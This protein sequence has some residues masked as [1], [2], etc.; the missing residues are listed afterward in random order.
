MRFSLRCR[1][2]SRTA[3]PSDRFIP[4]LI[5]LECLIAKIILKLTQEWVRSLRTLKLI[6][7]IFPPTVSWWCWGQ[8]T[9]HCTLGTLV[10]AAPLMSPMSPGSGVATVFTRD[11]RGLALT[12]KPRSSLG[13]WLCPGQLPAQWLQM[14]GVGS[15]EPWSLC[16]KSPKLKYYLATLTPR[17]LEI[18]W[19]LQVIAGYLQNVSDNYRARY[20]WGAAW[21]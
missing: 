17:T 3:L 6:V 19:R 4:R 14:R 18:V 7:R 16:L 21:V 9:G 2:G 20:L 13:L 15:W 1:V 5:P 12:R 10:R 11:E 8:V